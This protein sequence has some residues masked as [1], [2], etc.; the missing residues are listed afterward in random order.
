LKNKNGE[1]NMVDKKICIKEATVHD[2]EFDN[3]WFQIWN[4]GPTNTNCKNW[5]Q[6]SQFCNI[7]SLYRVGHFNPSTQI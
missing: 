6:I 1:F 3:F 4:H 2:F 5:L 7:I